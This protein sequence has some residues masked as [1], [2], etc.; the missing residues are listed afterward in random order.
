MESDAMEGMPSR[1]E[2]AVSRSAE[3]GG[4]FPQ[5]LGARISPCTPPHRSRQL[6]AS[7][8]STGSAAFCRFSPR[9]SWLGSRRTSSSALQRGF[10]ALHEGADLLGGS[11]GVLGFPVA[12]P[13]KRPHAGPRVL[14]HQQQAGGAEPRHPMTAD[15]RLVVQQLQRLVDL[16]VDLR[17][18]FEHGVT[19]Q[20]F[21]CFLDTPI[22]T[23]FR[24]G[25]K[26][27]ACRP[28]S[29][30]PPRATVQS[31]PVAHGARNR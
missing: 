31:A 1:D 10:G 7:S 3:C 6:P 27:A 17:L 28:A 5:G 19:G 13:V 2:N 24:V 29:C 25:C 30:H 11:V 18:A 21:H 15:A 12:Q 26:G 16:K 23:H 14:H 8:K 20:E 4:V 22:V 9:P